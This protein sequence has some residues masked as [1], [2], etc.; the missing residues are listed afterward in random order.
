MN[1]MNCKN[2]KAENGGGDSVTFWYECA[3]T[4][5]PAD[6]SICESC[7]HKKRIREETKDDR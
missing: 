3:L 7:E 6:L 2:A 4:G 5:E 1:P